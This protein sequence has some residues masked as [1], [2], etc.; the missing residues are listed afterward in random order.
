[1]L[2]YDSGAEQILKSNFSLISI[3]LGK[4]NISSKIGT[5][6]QYFMSNSFKLQHLNLEHNNLQLKGIEFLTSVSCSEQ[7][8]MN[9]RTLKHLN[10]SGN[11]IGDKGL[12]V[13]LR[14]VEK[15]PSLLE[16]RTAF[17]DI[18][19]TGGCCRLV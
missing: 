10:V 18:T 5:T 2:E 13:L 11:N 16:L 8:L 9:S 19:P 17:N 3:D 6:L 1:M 4:N 12:K 14:G 7:G 15:H